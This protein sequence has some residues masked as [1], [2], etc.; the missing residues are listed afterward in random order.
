MAKR[1]TEEEKQEIVDFINDYNKTNKRGGQ[2]KAVAKFGV[3]PIT[4]KKWVEGGGK[5]KRKTGGRKAKKVSTPAAPA[6]PKAAV[7]NGPAKKLERMLAISKEIE[8]LQSE[9]ESI[10]STL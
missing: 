1:Y 3:S 8:A 6:A 9:Y 7:P 5:K 10:K 4:L 2:A